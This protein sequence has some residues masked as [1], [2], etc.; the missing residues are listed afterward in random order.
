MR[1]S[2]FFD[3]ILEAQAQTGTVVPEIMRR[4][5]AEFG[6]DALEISYDYLD[7]N[8]ETVREWLLD[9]GLTV[10]CVY[11]FFDFGNSPDPE[12]GKKMLEL[13]A[14]FHAPRVL[15]VPGQ[16][17]PLEAAELAACRDTFADTDRFM[18]NSAAVRNMRDALTE[19]VRCG[20]DSGVTVT[21]EDFDG[22]LQPFS[23]MYQLLWFM[24]NV[25]G[26]GCALDTGNF[27]FSDEDPEKAAELLWPY[28]VHVHCKDRAMNPA[29]NGAFCRGLG[30]AAAGSGYIPMDRILQGLKAHGYDGCLAIE[31][32]GAPDQLSAIEKSAGFLK[33]YTAPTHAG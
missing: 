31:H 12:P 25:P 13:A 24:R 19:M 33:K 16:L 4:C 27:A 22:F 8:K 11:G 9:S 6:I 15:A 20:T 28:V 5:R 32:F 23:R 3:H 29:V 14:E 18:Q 21:M 7:K 1:L 17:N 26:L 10:S 30:P 2:V